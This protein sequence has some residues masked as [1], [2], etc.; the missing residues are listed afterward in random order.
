MFIS[1]SLIIAIIDKKNKMNK[2]IYK[3]ILDLKLK[4]L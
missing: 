4:M 1:P 3:L 2:L